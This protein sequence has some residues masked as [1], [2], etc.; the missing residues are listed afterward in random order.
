VLDLG[1]FKKI[2]NVS[3]ENSIFDKSYKRIY[4]KM[5]IKLPKNINNRTHYLDKVRPFIGKNILKVFTGQRR[6]G[7]SYLLFQLIAFLQEENPDEVKDFD[8]LL[9]ELE[10]EL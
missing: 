2:I 6:V 10:Q 8:L 3:I 7:K 4:I 9:D 1:F 5:I